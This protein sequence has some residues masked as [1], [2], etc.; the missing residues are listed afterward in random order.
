VWLSPG[1]SSA[2][3]CPYQSR[4]CQCQGWAPPRA[5]GLCQGNHS[6]LG[7]RSTFLYIY[8][9]PSVKMGNRQIDLCGPAG[10]GQAWARYYQGRSGTR[11]YRF[12]FSACQ[13]SWHSFK[14]SFHFLF[15]LPTKHK[16]VFG[17]E[18]KCI[19]VACT[20]HNSGVVENFPQ[21]LPLC[22]FHLDLV[23]LPARESPWRVFVV[24]GSALMRYATA[25]PF[26]A[27]QTWGMRMPAAKQQ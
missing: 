13:A 8:T 14:S 1:F 6:W 24:V 19:G 23:A 18:M 11:H 7:E 5:Y 2:H 4:E 10:V 9:D 26:A 16:G 20:T 12:V 21:D 3:A 22:E 27:P 25:V 17:R 15:L